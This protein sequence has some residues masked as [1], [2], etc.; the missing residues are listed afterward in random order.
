LQQDQGGAAAGHDV[1]V[2]AVSDQEARYRIAAQV[3]PPTPASFNP[4]VTQRTA[5]ANIAALAPRIAVLI[6]CYNEAEA[7]EGVVKDFAAA[8][9]AAT[10][11]VYD[12]NSTDETR[13]RAARAGA[14]VRTETFQGKGNVVRRMFADIEAEAYVLVDGDGT[15][16]AA[17][18]AVMV[19]MLLSNSLD[20]V[21]AAR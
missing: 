12:N 21:N 10:I 1:P 16:D 17:S 8:L 4:D 15:Y 6:P 5:A 20:M 14:I 9:P 2:A 13:A 18:A 11:Y 3:M 19:D 7:I